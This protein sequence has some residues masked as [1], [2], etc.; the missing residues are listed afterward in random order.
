M[1]DLF[2]L[3]TDGIDVEE[4]NLTDLDIENPHGL[5]NESG[6]PSRFDEER[7]FFHASLE[8]GRDQG[9]YFSGFGDYPHGPFADKDVAARVMK[10]MHEQITTLNEPPSEWMVSRK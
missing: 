2:A 3:R 6:T 10:E 8:E 1:S 9:W 4:I 7:I 5:R